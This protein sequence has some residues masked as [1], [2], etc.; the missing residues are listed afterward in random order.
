MHENKF[1]YKKIHKIHHRANTPIPIDYIYV[2]PFEWMSGFIGPYIGMVAMGGISI[3]SFWIYLVIRNFH[4]IHIHSGIQTSLLSKIIPF[5][6]TNEH[7]DIHHAKR[8]G[9]YSSTF[10]LWDKLLK[11]KI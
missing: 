5:Y 7:H 2:H 6:G 8:D 1:I 4:E 11:T 10:V 9:N 3:Y